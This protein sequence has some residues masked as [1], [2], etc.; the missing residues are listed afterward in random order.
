MAQSLDGALLRAALARSLV[1]ASTASSA[2]RVWHLLSL[3]LLMSRRVMASVVAQSFD[4]SLRRF[5]RRWRVLQCT[6]LRQQWLISFDCALLRAALA[7]SL[8]LA[9]AA[10]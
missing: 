8:V 2:C 4:D 6:P 10:T 9:I 7:H 3:N 5:E 1:R